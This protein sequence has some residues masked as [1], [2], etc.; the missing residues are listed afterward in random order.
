MAIFG[1]VTERNPTTSSMLT[2][3]SRHH[4]EH[5]WNAQFGGTGGCQWP[6]TRGH[7]KVISS[8]LFLMWSFISLFLLAYINGCE[9]ETLICVCNHLSIF[10][11]GSVVGQRSSVWNFTFKSCSRGPELVFR[12][13][14]TCL[15]RLAVARFV[16]HQKEETSELS[17]AN[18][19]EFMLIENVFRAAELT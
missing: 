3:K 6:A 11:R 9:F 8:S 4:F 10:W 16:P 12:Q 5:Q 19:W 14:W 17:I 18:W 15:P 7:P 13:W 1:C 2:L